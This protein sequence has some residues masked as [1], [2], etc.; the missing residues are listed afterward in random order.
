MP[1]DFLASLAL[2]GKT[3]NRFS[4]PEAGA[5]QRANIQL[6]LFILAR[7]GTATQ[8]FDQAGIGTLN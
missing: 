8:W 7:S 2:L 6:G 3:R 5:S 4:A 1:E